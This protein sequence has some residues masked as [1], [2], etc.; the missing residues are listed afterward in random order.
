MLC[1]K[2][3]YNDSPF[4]NP[5]YEPPTLNYTV[6]KKDNVRLIRDFLQQQSKFKGVFVTP[7]L[8]FLRIFAAYSK[9]ILESI[10]KTILTDK[11]I[12]YKS[13]SKIQF[14]VKRSFETLPL[15]GSVSEI[16]TY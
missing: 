5:N 4:P 13:D 9:T 2:G 10:A 11:S 12:K 6:C 14:L 8:N 1:F 3:D 7:L 15:F 16:P